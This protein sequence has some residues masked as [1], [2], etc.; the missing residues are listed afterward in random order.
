MSLKQFQSLDGGLRTSIVE[1]IEFRKHRFLALTKKGDFSPAAKVLIVGD[2]PA[3]DAPV[4]PSFH[5]T[6]FG[7]LCNSS[8]FINIELEKAGI[9]E[10]ELAWVNA[11]DVNKQY[12]DPAILNHPW[13]LIVAL[14]GQAEKWVLM[15]KKKC[16]R[17][18]HPSFH[19]R[20]HSKE[21]YNLIPILK[22]VCNGVVG[23]IGSN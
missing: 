17:V 9:E 7:A 12:T 19:K 6:P 11:R 20:F 4:D 18:S 2:C 8:L 16:V 22:K 13:K 5:Y 3:P 23:N 15:N 21:R 10:D 14:G 1:R